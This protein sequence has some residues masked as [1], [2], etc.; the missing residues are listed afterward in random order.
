MLRAARLIPFLLLAIAASTAGGLFRAG[1]RPHIYAL[2]GGTVVTEPGQTL[3]SATVVVRDGLIA[4]VGSDVEVPADAV[5]IDA[6]D[7]FVYPGLID[8]DSE[9]GLVAEPEPSRTGG[10]AA[11]RG[12]EVR[13]GAVH[14]IKRIHPEARVRDRLAPFDESRKR[15]LERIRNLGFTSVLVSPPSGI[16]RGRSTAILLAGDRPVSELILRDDVAQHAAFER[17]RFGDGY[18]TSLM[19]T[20]AALRQAFLDAQRYATWS[21]RYAEHPA[22]M[23]RPEIHAAFEAL[24]PVVSGKQPIIFQSSHRDDIGIAERLG[25]EFDLNYV[26]S[27]TGHEWEIADRVGAG[28]RALIYPIAGPDKPKV[29][30]DDAALAVSLQDLRRYLDSPQGPARLREAGVPLA[31]TLRGMKNTADF[32]KRMRKIIEAG[33]SEEAA[34]AGWT[35]VPA[36]LLGLE[37]VVGTI[38]PGKI[39]NLVVA[40]GTLFGEETRIREVFVDGVRYEVEVKEKPRG[41]PDAVVDPRG[42]WSVAFDFGTRSVQRVW[43]I[44]GEEGSYTGTAE[45]RGGTVTFDSVTLGGNVMTVVFPAREGRPA[46]EVTVVI[47]G[48]EFE[49]SVE[50]G[51][52]SV[53]IRGT[54]TTGPGGGER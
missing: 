30:D 46:N 45:T 49:G 14:P 20:V 51:P 34:L 11:R 3:P 18:P 53:E 5:R 31:F 17:G 24:G 37:K 36:G 38:E 29:K 27:G 21:R 25:R 1:E 7:R 48:G 32:P 13:P 52:R 12:P 47:E 19:G 16:L 41:D 40:D 6:T 43:S 4:A 28:G 33:L 44:E 23:A 26:V 9:M 42:E 39:A 10:D 15:D 35:V 22:G 2:T 54:R 8:P 50:F